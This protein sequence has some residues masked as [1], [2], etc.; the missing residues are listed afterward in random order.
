MAAGLTVAIRQL[1]ARA[2]ALSDPVLTQTSGHPAEHALLR[3]GPLA[4]DQL[5]LDLAQRL[6]RAGPWDEGFEAPLFDDEFLLQDSRIVGDDHLRLLLSPA[7]GDPVTAIA[8]RAA[9]LLQRAR[10]DG[11]KGPV[12]TAENDRMSRV[13]LK[14]ARCHA[15]F[16]LNEP[17]LHDPSH[18]EIKPLPLMMEDEREA[19]ERDDDVFC[20]CALKIDQV[21]RVMCT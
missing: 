17:Q 18:L 9:H 2:A 8:W 21:S 7:G 12:W 15:A 20:C 4:A 19:F 14:L 1:P 3:D 16:E 10:T 13:V 5:T 11:A 6:Q